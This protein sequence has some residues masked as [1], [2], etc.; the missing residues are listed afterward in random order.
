MVRIH[1]QWC[2]PNWTQGK[3]QPANAKGVD[4]TA[5]CNDSLDC[6]CRSHDKDCSNSLGCSAKA[7]RKLVIAALRY[8]NNPINKLFRPGVVAKA[9]AVAVGITA[10]STTRRR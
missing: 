8:A 4:F 5:P 10:A 3:S 6:A 7:D 2:G 9:S 1:G